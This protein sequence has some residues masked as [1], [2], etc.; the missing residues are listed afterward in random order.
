M[1]A[2]TL[3]QIVAIADTQAIITRSR[4]ERTSVHVAKIGLFFGSNTGNTE[5]V[6]YQ[7]KEEFDRI[8]PTL[9]EVHNIGAASPEQLQSYQYLILGVPTWNTGQLQDDW[10]FFLPR[11]QGVDM[12]GRKIAI[13]GLGDQNG[14]GFNFLD[15]VGMLADAFMENGAELYGLWPIQQY[16]FEESLAQVEDHF[17]GLGIDQDGQ[18]ESTPNRLKEWALQVLREF[19]IAVPQA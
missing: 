4:H 2:N 9:V 16:Q 18:P 7:M 6:A 5:Y 10:E 17:L 3:E 14:Y 11:M 13:F 15:A 1:Q 19:A 8:D 12:S